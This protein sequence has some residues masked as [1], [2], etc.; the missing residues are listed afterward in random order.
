MKVGIIEILSTLG[1]YHRQGS[2]KFLLTK[3]YAS[4]TPQA[5]SVWC[6]QLGHQTVYKT[7]YG[8]GGLRNFLHMDLDIVFISCYT[9]ASPLAYAL[10]KMYRMAG[11]KTVIGGAHAASFPADCLRFFDWVVVNCD[12][13]LIKDIL[14]GQFEPNLVISSKS[15]FTE[16]PL[17][18]E[19]IAEIK[20]SSFFMGRFPHS[21]TTIP[22]LASIGCP[23]QCNFCVDWNKPYRTL[24]KDRLRVDLQYVAK[25]LPNALI[26]FHDPNFAV[27]FEEIFSVLES[28]PRNLRPKYIFE[29][30]L[31]VLRGSRV[32]RLQDTNC[33]AVAPGIESWTSYS[34]KSSTTLEDSSGKVRKV[35]EHVRS[36]HEYVPYIQGNFIFGLDT[37]SGSKPFELTKFFIDQAP[38]VWPAINIPVPFGG[39]PL[40]EEQLKNRRILK[41]MPFGFYYNPHSVVT[42]ANY[43][44]IEYYEKMI[45]LVAYITSASTLKRRL[46]STV[47]WKIKMIHWVRTKVLEKNIES[48]RK[49]LDMLH[50]DPQFLSFHCG[51]SDAL[52]EFYHNE[53]DKMLG[54]HAD[55]LTKEEHIPNLAQVAPVY[56]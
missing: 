24:S 11:V 1:T 17:V 39:T 25:K 46:E 28:Q 8:H 52:P 14:D 33:I 23:Y 22:I 6:R 53:Y 51:E 15:P 40:F 38:F 27:K 4:I 32:K 48:Y 9:Q 3:Q 54:P 20:A 29:S 16:V 37:D 49:I 47:Y 5:V 18:E 45:D 43:T 13:T 44:P 19:R 31:S 42:F 21:V 36:L 12:K 26:G 56:N 2:Y 10:A 30:S 7:Y 55:L 50:S 35:V 34:N 41:N